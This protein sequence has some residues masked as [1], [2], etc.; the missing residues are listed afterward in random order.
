M[1][2]DAVRFLKSW[3]YEALMLHAQGVPHR[4]LAKKYDVSYQSIK[5]IVNS[6]V[7]RN[8]LETIRNQTITTMREVQARLQSVAPEMVEGLINEARTAPESATRARAQ[9]RLLEMAGH[10]PTQ[11]M[12]IERPDAVEEEYKDQDESQIKQ[13]VLDKISAKPVK[14]KDK[15]PDGSLLQ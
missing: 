5:N 11:H 1:A 6:A 4:E 15:G 10:Q 12:V 2:Q 9:I 8:L 14:A 13:R 3:H 7:G